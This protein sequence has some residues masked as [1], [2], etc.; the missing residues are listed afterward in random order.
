VNLRLTR[1]FIRSAAD[2][3][4]ATCY[5]ESSSLVKRSALVKR[6]DGEAREREE[7]SQRKS[8]GT[9]LRL[10]FLSRHAGL[11]PHERAARLC[12]ISPTFSFSRSTDRR[13]RSKYSELFVNKCA[14]ST[15]RIFGMSRFKLSVSSLDRLS[16]S[17]WPAIGRISP[18]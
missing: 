4:G 10:F 11:I 1:G 16:L 17:L 8:R 5:S 14:N 12:P 3:A 9:R 18:S 2:T 7:K 6:I 15:G 13:G